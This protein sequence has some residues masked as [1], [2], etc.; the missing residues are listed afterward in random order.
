MATRIRQ[1]VYKQNLLFQLPFL[2][3]TC[4]P[5]ATSASHVDQRVRARCTALY[6][7]ALVM[8]KTAALPLNIFPPPPPFPPIKFDLANTTSITATSSRKNN[9]QA[10]YLQLRELWQCVS[11]SQHLDLHFEAIFGYKNHHQLRI[12]GLD[13][14]TNN[15]LFNLFNFPNKLRKMRGWVNL[16]SSLLPLVEERPW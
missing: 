1:S 13:T 15:E 12:T 10:F 7:S 16:V 6:I 4:S 14:K 8:S 9:T 3:I 5:Q 2:P 11:N